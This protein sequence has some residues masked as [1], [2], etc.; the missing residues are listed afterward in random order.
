VAF[1]HP[2]MGVHPDFA[3]KSGGGLYADCLAEMDHRVGQIL[4]AIEAACIADNTIVE[5]SSGEVADWKI[6][7][8]DEQRDWWTAPAKLGTPKAFD[9]ITDPK[10]EYPQTALLNTWNAG[11]AIE[12]VT[13]FE[14]TQYPPIAPGTPDPCTPPR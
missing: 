1:L 12:I 8:Y 13:K 9:L 4:D 10:E 3:G 2:P 11:P 7:F 14:R 5:F 6:A